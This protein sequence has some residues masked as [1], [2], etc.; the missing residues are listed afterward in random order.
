M[1][2]TSH[3]PRITNHEPRITNR[4]PR[5]TNRE[6][7]VQHRHIPFAATPEAH[8]VGL[9]GAAHGHE[10]MRLLR[11]VRQHVREVEHPESRI[12]ARHMEV[13]E[14]MDG[15][16]RRDRIPRAHAPVGGADHE[17][18][19]LAAPPADPE[20]QEEQVPQHAQHRPA[21]PSGGVD[22]SR[23][24]RASVPASRRVEDAPP[25]RC[26]LVGRG[27]RTRRLA[28]ERELVSLR[29]QRSHDLPD[30][31]RDAAFAAVVRNAGDEKLH[32]CAV[33]FGS[34]GVRSARPPQWV[35]SQTRGSPS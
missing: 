31:H 21:R 15:G 23:H 30:V 28:Q 35:R 26:R 22:D 10:A 27:L 33:R 12:F 25:Y 4:E 6:P 2:A 16:Y 3:E 1:R 14:V 9:G 29:Q 19:E 8:H 20:R 17:P 5:T 32:G 18:V 11:E 13:R 24:G 7:V 34:R